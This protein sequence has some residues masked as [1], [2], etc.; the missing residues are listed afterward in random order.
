MQ[1]PGLE[2]ARSPALSQNASVSCSPTSPES[3]WLILNDGCLYRLQKILAI[4]ENT[5]IATRSV[6]CT[7]DHPLLNGP[8]P[9]TIDELSDFFL[10]EGVKLAVDASWG[11]IEEWG[12]DVSE[13][14]HLVATTS[15]NSA[16][17]GYDYHVAR[18]LGITSSVERTLLQGVGCAGGLAAL[19]T[20][21]NIAL[22]ASF[23]QKPARIL[24]VASEL[25]STLA[26]SELDSLT[27]NQELRIAMTLYSDGASALVLSNGVGDARGEKPLYDL[28]AWDNWTLPDTEKDITFDVHP[29]GEPR[30]HAACVTKSPQHC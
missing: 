6:A 5:G 17:P 25:V 24:V 28:L 14:T 2:E 18:E 4:N 15:T 7:L 16:N 23:L 26:R 19:R 10:S 20:A 27:Q 1:A 9:P 8:E 11:A 30:L 13:L 12:G 3:L 22:L 29:N 21:A